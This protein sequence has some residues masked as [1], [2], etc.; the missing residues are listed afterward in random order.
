MSQTYPISYWHI[1]NDTCAFNDSVTGIL[2][3]QTV[4]KYSNMNPEEF[5]RRFVFPK[6]AKIK[7]FNV[8]FINTNTV[9]FLIIYS[10]Q[11][12][13]ILSNTGF[14]YID[15][16]NKL[17]QFN[18]PQNKDVYIFPIE[19]NSLMTINTNATKLVLIS[20]PKTSITNQS[21]NINTTIETHNSADEKSSS[22]EDVS[23]DEEEGEEDEEEEEEDEEEG[24]DDGDEVGEEEEEEEVGEEDEE[25][26]E[27]DEEVGEEVGEEEEEEEEDAEEV[28]A[29][30]EDEE[31][32]E[33]DEEEGDEDGEGRRSGRKK[34]V[35]KKTISE[36]HTRGRKKQKVEV[37]FNIS[38][39]LKPEQFNHPEN[40]SV[41]PPY[42]NK[43]RQE[44]INLLGKY[45]KFSVID[46]YK[47]ELSIYNYAITQAEKYYIYAH[48]E[49]PVFIP[50]YIDKAKSLI[51]NLCEDFGVCNPRLKTLIQ[52]H[53]IDLLTL[54]NMS[55]QEMW[56]EN[57]QAIKDE[58]MKLEQMRKDAIKSKATDI[59][60][61]PRCAK[62]NSIY[63]ELQTRSA[64]EPMTQFITCQE[65]GLHWKQG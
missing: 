10:Y 47:I 64:D 51:S 35:Q 58:Q 43:Y 44:V 8:E 14:S 26:G 60:K 56:P 36:P 1:I 18:L 2:P 33:E 16:D 30:I 65:C 12:D 4:T 45:C 25:V 62:R 32:E 59:F 38:Q 53:K 29:T 63:F 19:F 15:K 34:K 31:G 55:Y 27:E 61:C 6:I 46:C 9:R 50:Y 54:A 7:L 5:Y 23:S 39:M 57:W 37:I 13:E 28:D 21:L 41:L 48:W 17:T 40:E 20:K 3:K 22:D 49:N 52:E 11:P 42:E 24:A